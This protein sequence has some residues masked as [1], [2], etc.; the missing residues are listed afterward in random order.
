MSSSRLESVAGSLF[1][2]RGGRSAFRAIYSA[3]FRT[4]NYYT[5]LTGPFSPDD[6]LFSSVEEA[7]NHVRLETPK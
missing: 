3:Y 1:R 2:Q 5:W 7:V 6:S 4:D